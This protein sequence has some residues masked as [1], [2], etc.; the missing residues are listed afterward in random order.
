SRTARLEA[1]AERARRGP[2]DGLLVEVRHG[3]AIRAD[4]ESLDPRSCAAAQDE[5][6][7][8]RGEPAV[9]RRDC[10][11]GDRRVAV[12]RAIRAAKARIQRAV[13]VEARH[14]VAQAGRC[15][16]LAVTARAEPVALTHDNVAA[17]QGG[18]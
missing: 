13:C 8:E 14:E 6:S 18:A 12:G 9:K 5:L 2:K 11:P 16:E 15:R 7:V 17:G 4:P 10:A 3:S 1:G